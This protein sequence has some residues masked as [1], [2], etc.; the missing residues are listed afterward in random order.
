MQ[1]CALGR[2]ELS[3]NILRFDLTDTCESRVMAGARFGGLPPRAAPSSMFYVRGLDKDTVGN[4]ELAEH[5]QGCAAAA[6]YVDRKGK[7]RGYVAS[8]S[9]QPQLFDIAASQTRVC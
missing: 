6:V 4:R 9:I 5:F 1:L 2:V 8:F 7:S 3:G